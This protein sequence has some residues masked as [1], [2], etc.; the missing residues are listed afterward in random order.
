MSPD[1]QKIVEA[2]RAGRR[3]VI[4]SHARPDGDA[5]GSEMAA[6]YALRALGKQVRVVNVDPPPAPFM[7]FPGVPDIEVA[8][9]ASGE[10][11]VSIVMECSSLA[12]TGVKGLDRATV[13]NIDHHPGNSSYGQLNWFDGTAAACGEMVFDL[14][15]ALGTPLTREVATHIYIAIL[16]DTGSFH[17]SSISPRTFEICREALVT[18]GGRHCPVPKAT[19]GIVDDLR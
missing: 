17:F 5:I 13:I 2:I 1:L 11:D 6:A 10:F 7:Q 14:V 8:S 3:F 4:S 12:R 16:T 19:F 15:K 9:E 18:D